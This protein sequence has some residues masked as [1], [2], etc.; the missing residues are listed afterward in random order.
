[1]RE[2]ERVNED[3]RVKEDGERSREEGGRE[4]ER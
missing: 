3:E 4:E 2:L 1:M